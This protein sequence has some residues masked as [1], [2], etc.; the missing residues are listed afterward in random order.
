MCTK[1]V[2]LM[3]GTPKG[4]TRSVLEGLL[5]RGSKVLFSCQDQNVGAKEL[6]RLSSL[7]GADQ[8]SF[9]PVDPS[10]RSSLEST[11]IR[12]LDIFGKIN[13]VVNSTAN[14]ILKVGEE[15]LHGEIK[16]VETI[17]DNRLID[18]DV[19]GIRLMGDLAKEYL[20]RQNG[21]DGGTFL[22]L[23]SST[24]LRGGG[25]NDGCT[26][27]GTAKALRRKI[28]SHGVKTVTIYQPTIEYPEISP[29][30]QINDNQHTPY[31]QWN[32]YSSYIR[33]Y[34]GYMAIHVGDT[35]LPG[36]AWRFDKELRIQRVNMK[37]IRG[38]QTMKNVQQM[39]L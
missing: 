28:D 11:L 32:R 16:D 7:Y 17:L 26:V 31:S 37:D 22:N 27:L 5:K 20:G 18:E 3:V 9:N 25:G 30:C 35:A 21:F 39:K 29:A 8:V 36:S 2:C 4:F 13:L 23:S 6:H 33:E 15:D 19:E 12:T 10:S 24:E 14:N 34:T 38:D 1:S